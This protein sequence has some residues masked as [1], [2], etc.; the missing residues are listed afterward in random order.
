VEP[1]RPGAALSEPAVVAVADRVS[2]TPAQIVLRW[3]LQQGRILVPK[4]VTPS[5]IAENP[6]ILTFDVSD[7]DLAAIDSLEA[8]GRTGPHPATFN[9]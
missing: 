5:R 7:V 1:A 4:S 2:R 6:D 3:H 8:D 9:R